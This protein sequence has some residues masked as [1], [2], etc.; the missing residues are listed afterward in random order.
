MINNDERKITSI[1][2]NGSNGARLKPAN[3]S[4]RSDKFNNDKSLGKYE[5]NSGVNVPQGNYFE[6]GD[7]AKY[8][9]K[10][11]EGS[12]GPTPRQTPDARNIR[13]SLPISNNE[14]KTPQ[15]E[16]Y[17]QNRSKQMKSIEQYKAEE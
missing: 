14:K 15:D 8:N 5:P 12:N 2:T 1:Y 16:A 7:E 11:L 6:R 17:C 3:S 10:K 13:I 9:F 4:K